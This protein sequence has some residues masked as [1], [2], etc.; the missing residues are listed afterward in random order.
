MSFAWKLVVLKQWR[1]TAWSIK[2]F[3]NWSICKSIHS[4]CDE[5]ADK[6]RIS[7]LS[8]LDACLPRIN[9]ENTSNIQREIPP[10][11]LGCSRRRCAAISNPRQNWTNSW[12]VE[13]M[14]SAPRHCCRHPP[15]LRMMR[16]AQSMPRN[17]HHCNGKRSCESREEGETFCIHVQYAWNGLDWRSSRWF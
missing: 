16:F 1:H 12:Q 17:L 14:G 3:L 15:R 10:Y 13:G 7:W 2:R 6:R 9:E 4:D 8:V 5:I 11:F